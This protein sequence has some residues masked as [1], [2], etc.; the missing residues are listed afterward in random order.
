[1]RRWTAIACGV[2]AATTALG[3]A[4]RGQES[5]RLLDLDGRTVDPFDPGGSRAI[6]FVFA[7]LDCPVSNR[8]APELARL[9]RSFARRGV[10]FTLVYPGDQ[11]A[12]TIERHVQEYGYPFGALRD[13]DFGF[14]D[15]AGATV[16]P[17]AAVFDARGTLRY[18]GRID[19]RYMS[20]GRMRPA[21]TRHDL[22]E[23]LEALL[24]GRPVSPARTPAAGCLIADLR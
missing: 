16:T 11:P 5:I 3:P 1:M 7:R 19:D 13:P 2:L 18:L 6:V 20:A 17:E 15:R 12:E 21:A 24:A 23:A 8:Y 14:V 10:E 9:F 4:G 22:K